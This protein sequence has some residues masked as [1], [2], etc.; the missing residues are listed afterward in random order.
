MNLPAAISSSSSRTK[1]SLPLR[2]GVADHHGR[3][4]AAGH[5][6]GVAG[7]RLTKLRN[8]LAGGDLEFVEQNEVL[9]A[10][11]IGSSRPPWPR[12][13]RRSPDRC[14]RRETYKAS[15]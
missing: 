15:Q 2:S 8:E 10:S 12:P 1:C 14:S 5:Q 7:G 9:V 4:R 3:G 11:Q 13:R 6:T